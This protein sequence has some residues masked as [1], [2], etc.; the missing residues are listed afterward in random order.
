MK[1]PIGESSRLLHLQLRDPG[2][3]GVAPFQQLCALGD[4]RH[5]IG[6]TSPGSFLPFF[7]LRSQRPD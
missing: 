1:A 5:D 3:G 7:D 2:Q 4:V 6:T